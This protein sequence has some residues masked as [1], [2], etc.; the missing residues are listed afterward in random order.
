MFLGRETGA[1][2]WLMIKAEK[3]GTRSEMQEARGHRA[4]PRQSASTDKKASTLLFYSLSLM[5][6]K[7]CSIIVM[8]DIFVAALHDTRTSTKSIMRLN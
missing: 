1:R 6:P 7:H 3:T 4:T 5:V 8:C 2:D